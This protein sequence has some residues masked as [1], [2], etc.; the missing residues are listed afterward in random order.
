MYGTAFTMKPK[1][2]Q[3]E[4]IANV[5]KEWE[6]QKKPNVK[7]VKAGYLY[8]FDQGGMMGVAIFETKEDYLANANDPQQDQWFQKLRNLLEEDPKWNDG[9]VL[10]ATTS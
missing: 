3:E 8:K 1:P 6:Q 2:G 9:E 7:G 5:F 4:E 10:V